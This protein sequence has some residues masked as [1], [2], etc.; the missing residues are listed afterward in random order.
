MH[1]Y[2]R[3]RQAFLRSVGT[4]EGEARATRAER[5]STLTYEDVLRERVVFG[6]PDLVADRLQALIESLGLSGLIME[7]NTGGR[8][9][10]ACVLESIRL[11][12][13]EVAPRLHAVAA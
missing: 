6:T 9:P 7:G 2:N 1:H 10:P 4:A 5:L 11:F 8:V 13:K 12:G 3:L